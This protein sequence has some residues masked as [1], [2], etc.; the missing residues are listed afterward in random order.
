MKR[1]RALLSGI[2]RNRWFRRFVFAICIALVFR[3]GF[4]SYLEQTEVGIARNLVTGEMWIYEAGLRFVPPWVGVSHID[5]R[6]VRVVVSTT[7]HTYSAK[8]VQF[9]PKAWRVFV[10]R[11]GWRLYWL[12]NRFSFNWGFKEECRGMVNILRGYA[13]STQKYSFIKVLEE[14]QE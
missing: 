8:L 5:T 7:A 9:E 13:Y 4:V 14:Y 12:D 6:P 10:D 2:A 3:F 1:T 11:E